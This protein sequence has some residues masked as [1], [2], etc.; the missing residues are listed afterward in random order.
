MRETEIQQV[1]ASD[2]AISMTIPNRS[3]LFGYAI[4]INGLL[5][6]KSEYSF[7]SNSLILPSTLNI[8]QGDI[9]TF[10]YLHP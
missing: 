7:N 9:I 10:Q 3:T 2:G 5:Q 4:F 6:S 8:I 1:A